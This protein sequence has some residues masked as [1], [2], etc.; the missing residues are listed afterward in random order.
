MFIAIQ[1][2]KQSTRN[3]VLHSIISPCPTWAPKSKFNL[4]YSTDEL[5]VLILIGNNEFRESRKELFPRNLNRPL[6]WFLPISLIL[7]FPKATTQH[8][9][10]FLSNTHY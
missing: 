4:D 6:F 7:F 3:K 5:F 9:I 8:A 10:F 2:I 1:D